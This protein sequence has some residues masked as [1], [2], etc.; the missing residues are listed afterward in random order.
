MH[1]ILIII[2]CLAKRYK[3]WSWNF[4]SF[5]LQFIKKNPNAR[6]MRED[7]LAAG[8]LFNQKEGQ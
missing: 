7:N 4:F 1:I 2:S 3:Y 5:G 6:L 8:P